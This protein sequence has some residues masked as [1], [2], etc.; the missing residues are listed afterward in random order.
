MKN[1][2]FIGTNNFAAKI[3]E[4]LIKN[5]V[6][7]NSTFTKPDAKKGRGQKISPYPVKIIS[8]KSNIKCF[9]QKNINS[10]TSI[11][12][13]KNL[14]PDIILMTEYGEKIA[15][16]IINIPKYGILNIHPS[17]LPKL[18][19]PTPIQTAILT[20]EKETGVSIIKI[21]NKI[22]SGLILN[23]MKYK[24]KK[25]DTY[26]TLMKKLSVL[27][28]KCIIQTLNGIKYKKITPYKQN[29]NDA[30]ITIKIDKSFYKI[31]WNDTA[32]NIER[33]IRALSGIKYPFTFLK[34]MQIKIAYVKILKKKC[35]STP[36]II[37]NITKYGIDVSTK[38]GLIRIK[39]IQFQGKNVNDIKN[40]VNSNTNFFNIGEKFE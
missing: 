40:I 20:G 34:N 18:R 33:K 27:S 39:K 11:K 28:V 7:I 13:I 16:E 8:E 1:I 12:I 29:E 31:N 19:G 24:I 37:I 22:D 32:I 3:L 25:Y 15:D 6:K 2:I 5:K 36:G 21:N 9:T 26:I 38:N 35:I 14:S 30:T 23:I 4:K 10:K 17:I